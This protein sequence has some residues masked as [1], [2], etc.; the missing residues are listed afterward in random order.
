MHGLGPMLGGKGSGRVF[1]HGGDN[2]SYHAWIE[3]YLE[4]GDGFVILTNGDGGVK[5]RGEIRNAFS[6]AIGLGVSPLVRVVDIDL[7]ASR[8]DDYAGRYERDTTI[9]ADIGRILLDRFDEP[10]FTIARA[11]SGFTVSFGE[12]AETAPLLALAPDRFV[13]DELPQYEFVLHRDAFGKV[14]G[15]TV[16]RR[17]CEVVFPAPSVDANVG[18]NNQ[19]AL[20]RTRP[21]S[22]E[23]TD[24]MTRPA[25]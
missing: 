4:T 1:F 18:R 20:R 15:A 12:P 2:D 14:R 9:P 19:R 13:G 17:G 3:G 25:P 6:D 23:F 11:G 21:K 10:G 5:L 24:A 22:N 7:S 16:E 8:Y